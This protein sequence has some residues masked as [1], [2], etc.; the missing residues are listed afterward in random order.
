[1]IP[2]GPAFSSESG[3]GRIS[4]ATDAIKQWREKSG[5]VRFPGS[6]QTQARGQAS[7]LTIPALTQARVRPA[8][9]QSCRFTVYN[10]LLWPQPGPSPRDTSPLWVSG[11]FIHT[12][13]PVQGQNT[14]L[15][16][17]QMT[18]SSFLD[19]LCLFLF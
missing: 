19:S 11:A 8:A 7:H 13:E 17:H 1:M 4:H 14:T 2:W 5:T 9:F 15:S 16:M 12:R 6:V 10:S 18:V 3:R